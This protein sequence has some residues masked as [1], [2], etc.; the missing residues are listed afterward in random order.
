MSD[1]TPSSTGWGTYRS[2]PERVADVVVVGPG[3]ERTCREQRPPRHGEAV[4]RQAALLPAGDRPRVERVDRRRAMRARPAPSGSPPTTSRYRSVRATTS[5][6]AVTVHGEARRSRPRPT[7]STPGA[8]RDRRRS[9]RWSSVGR[10]TRAGSSRAA[11]RG[12]PSP[13]GRS[14]PPRAPASPR[15]SSWVRRSRGGASASVAPIQAAAPR[16]RCSSRS[17]RSSSSAT[18]AATA[19]A[20]SSSTASSAYA[21]SSSRVRRGSRP[22]SH[23]FSFQDVGNP[24]QPQPHPRLRR[25]FRDL[26]LGGDL[27]VGPAPEVRELDRRALL[28]RQLVERG[29]APARR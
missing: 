27:A 10:A 25:A 17:A 5:V 6:S 26:E 15:S 3:L 7:P 12:A 23:S 21:P 22:L 1:I 9:G 8:R 29:C 13:S 11:P 2:R 16:S 14:A 28:R 20:S 24:C 18:S 4:P 19:A